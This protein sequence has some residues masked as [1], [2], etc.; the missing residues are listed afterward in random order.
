MRFDKKYIILL[1]GFF[2]V[3]VGF[4]IT[5]PV[6]PFYIQK[7][8]DAEGISSEKM[9]LHV[10]LITGAYPL[11]QFL[12]SPFIGSWSDKV[13]RRPLI[14]IGSLG[15]SIATFLF[16][17]STNIVMLYAFRLLAG[18]FSAAFLTA[19]ISYVADKTTDGT[20]AQGITT[21]VGATAFGAVAGP[22]LGNL[23]SADNIFI[24]H[25][26]FNKFAFSFLIS[27]LL[28][29]IVFGFLLFTLPESHK[30]KERLYA[31]TNELKRESVLYFFKSVP[32]SVI[33][34]LSFSFISQLALGMFEG[35]YALHSKRL[36]TFSPKQMNIVFI[37]CGSVMG[38]LSL[39]P[40]AWLIKKWGEKRLLPFG[41]I[42]LGLGIALLMTSKRMKFILFNVSLISAGV[43]ILTPC[44][45]SLITKNLG[46]NNGIAL[47]VYNST[48]TLG[49]M[50]GVL[51][52]SVLLI[53]FEHLPYLLVS[54][55]L[56]TAAYLST[57]YGGSARRAG[58]SKQNFYP[59]TVK[60]K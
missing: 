56:L 38:I 58:A 5:L 46:K 18:L 4:G 47:G 28:A 9:W 60:S 32:K 6:L 31:V 50:S 41:L 37:V 15:Y 45:A 48:V 54:F 52:G 3:M 22:L 1:F 40:V 20:R 17:I 44:L 33:L 42:I 34:L 11:M 49:Q 43:A 19:S 7:I 55:I 59:T 51:L 30:R 53:W 39:G 25:L 57:R 36:F 16:A 27:S 35:T 24:A 23:F 10:G 13:G 8:F 26:Q 29:L 14:L 21:L 12:F 2:V